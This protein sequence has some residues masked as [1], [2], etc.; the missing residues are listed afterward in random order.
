MVLNLYDDKCFLPSFFG[1]GTESKGMIEVVQT[2]YIGG[3]DERKG[4][5]G[6]RNR[7]IFIYKFYVIWGGGIKHNYY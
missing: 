2:V 1:G 7:Y 3:G 6:D 4:G 5:N